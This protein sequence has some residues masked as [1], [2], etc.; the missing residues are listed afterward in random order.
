MIEGKISQANGRLKTAAVGVRIEAKGDRLYLRATLPPR[1]G[2]SQQRAYQQRIALHYRA[3]P[4]GV[5]L[6][7]KEAR[8]IGALIDCGSLIGSRIWAIAR[9]KLRRSVFILRN[10]QRLI[11]QKFLALLGKPSIKTS[12]LLWTGANR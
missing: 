12:S 1:P 9:L 4:Y 3:N 10:L 2:S 5:S 11:S 8:K 6:A 7:E